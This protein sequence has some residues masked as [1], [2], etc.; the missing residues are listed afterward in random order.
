MSE[1]EVRER[2][3]DDLLNT[4]LEAIAGNIPHVRRA[5]GLDESEFDRWAERFLLMAERRGMRI[6]IE[7][8]V[9]RES[10]KEG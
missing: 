1:Q 7:P 5:L 9:P 6:I 3:V 4:R 10:D 8:M 2:L